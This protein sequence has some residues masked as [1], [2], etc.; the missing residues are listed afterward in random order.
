MTTVTA[1][2]AR[3]MPAVRGAQPFPGIAYAIIYINRL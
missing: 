3:T 1:F 2:Y